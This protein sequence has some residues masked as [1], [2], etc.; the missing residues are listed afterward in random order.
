MKSGLSWEFFDRFQGLATREGERVFGE[1][2]NLSRHVV[3]SFH[4]QA[5]ERRSSLSFLPA[6]KQYAAT[7]I[8]PGERR[9]GSTSETF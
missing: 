7:G 5:R 8:F 3:D 2:D 1:P 9:N 4:L 6:S